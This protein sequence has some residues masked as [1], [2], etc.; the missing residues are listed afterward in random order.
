MK[1]IALLLVLILVVSAPLSALAVGRMGNEIYGVNLTF[2]GTTATCK[3]E[4]C[5][6]YENDYSVITMKLY[7]GNQ[8]LHQWSKSSNG[9]FELV[10]TCTVTKGKTYTLTMELMV[11]GTS[12]SSRSVTKTC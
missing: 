3:A 12:R 6:D 8:L 11:N 2:N 10:R 9:S 7:S 5:P 1:K 4:V